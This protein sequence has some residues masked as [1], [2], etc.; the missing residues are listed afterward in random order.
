MVDGTGN[1]VQQAAAGA[2]VTGIGAEHVAIQGTTR[3][4]LRP[5]SAPTTAIIISAMT[6]CVSTP[7][8]SGVDAVRSTKRL[9]PR[10]AHRQ[11]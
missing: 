6:V 3:R 11:S 5:T 9:R 1:A 8:S 2:E 10:A 4:A 7:R